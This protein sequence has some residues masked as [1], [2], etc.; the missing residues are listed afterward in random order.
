MVR[1]SRWGMGID[2]ADPTTDVPDIISTTLELH[3]QAELMKLVGSSVAYV[4][5]HSRMNPTSRPFRV[6]RGQGEQDVPNPRYLPDPFELLVIRGPWA[7][8]DVASCLRL[9]KYSDRMLA[10]DLPRR[11]RV[12]RVKEGLISRSFE[13]RSI[14]Q[15]LYFLPLLPGRPRN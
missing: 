15:K 13:S 3:K 6:R 11:I 1:A 12:S 2:V 7:V 10:F 4:F 14:H 5:D 9:M 8:P